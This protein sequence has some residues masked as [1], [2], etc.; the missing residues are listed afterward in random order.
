MT[1]LL[2]ALIEL[3]GGWRDAFPRQ[4]SFLRAISHVLALSAVLGRRT[5]TRVILVK[6]GGYGKGWNSEYKLFSRSPWDPPALFCPVWNEYLR[7]YPDGPIRVAV[8]ET[9]LQKT[10][11]SI[12]DVQWMRD[13][14]SPPFQT[15]LM[16]GL[17][18]LQ[19]SLLFPHYREQDC[20]PRAMPVNFQQSTR[21]HK[22]GK[23]ATDEQKTEYRK[24]VKKVNLSTHALDLFGQLR[25]Q[26]DRSGG[27]ERALWLAVDGSFANQTIFR[28]VLPRTELIARCRKDAR[29]CYPAP[30]GSKRVYDP[31]VF[32]PEQVLNNAGIAFQE[33]FVYLA[34]GWRTIRYKEINGVLWQG[35]ARSRLLR[36]IVVEPQPYRR[37]P[38]SRIRRR[39]PS[40]LLVTD[41]LSSAQDLLQVYC[42]RWQIEVNHFEEKSIFGVGEAQVRSPRSVP[43]HPALAVAGYSLILLAG[44]KAF[45]PGRTDDYQTLP[46]WRRKSKR[47]SMLDLLTVLRAEIHSVSSN[48]LENRH[49]TGDQIAINTLLAALPPVIDANL[50]RHAFT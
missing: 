15:N 44:L 21:V 45:G 40:F 22:P 43:R 17:R 1:P 35:G 36:L 33:T 28:A 3:L 23:R 50:V 2:D 13:P 18:F 49:E 27:T 39:D 37:S 31:E 26:A 7:R 38:N 34:G 6:G 8:D 46:R 32:T 5:I 42:D 47:P 29:L 20:P 9:G 25:E 48:K 24:A 10:G 12:P 30:K 16:L 4:R 14:L 41:L 19:A 11:R